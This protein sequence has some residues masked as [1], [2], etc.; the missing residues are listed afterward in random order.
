MHRMLADDAGR[1]ACQ[2]CGAKPVGEPL[3]RPSHQLPS[4]GRTLVLVVIGSLLTLIFVSQTI[5]A[6]V[7]IA[8]VSLP[9]TVTLASIVP[10][11]LLD[12]STWLAAAETA[13]WRLKWLMIPLTLLVLFG[14]RKLYRSIQQSPAQFSG[15]RYARRGYLASAAVPLL[16]LVFIGIT[17]PTRLAHR[18]W[19][20][21][22]RGYAYIHRF[23]RAQ[24]EYRAKT[25]GITSDPN[26]LLKELPDPDGSL[27]EA[28][29]N[30]DISGYKP[31]ADL[32]AVP[33]KKPQQLRGAVIKNASIS[34]ADDA[35]GEKLSFTNYELPLPGPDKIAGTEDDLI[36]RDGVIYKAAEDPR[37]S[38]NTT[39]SSQTRKP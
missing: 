12:F 39:G 35:P 38:A 6:A 14:S 18:N 7:E 8:P 19:G 1:P 26:D 25:G 13:S 16:V 10:A 31:T 33:T 4:F 15:L 17:V 3:P 2:S 29:K 9:T 21:E 11:G 24:E 5:I 23:D 30:L 28:L 32:A 27:A 34:T 37:R 36:V 22:A 20:I